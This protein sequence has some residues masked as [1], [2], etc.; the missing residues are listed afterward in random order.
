MKAHQAA[1]AC[2]VVCVALAL[3]MPWLLSP[4]SLRVMVLAVISAIAVVGLCFAFGYAGLVDLGQAAFLGI[5]AYATALLTTRAGLGFWTALPAA[6]FAG[7]V[8]AILLGAPL[9]RLR[10]HYLAL[11]TVGLNVTMEIVTKN[12][13]GL[14][15]GEDGISGIPGVALFG[16]PITTDRAYYFLALA[17]LAIAAVIGLALRASRF[18]RSMIAVRD[19][20]LAADACGVLVFRTK[21]VA[22]TLASVYGALSGVLY[23]HY[24]G[25]IAP[26]DFDSVR[27]ITLLVMLIVGGE[28]SILG[29]IG[30]AVLVSFA[31]EWLRF[32]GTAY[33]TVFGILIMLVLVLLP[34][35]AAGAVRSLLA[36]LDRRPA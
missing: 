31:P 8:L 17:F 5:G 2:I 18:G 23:A 9:L 22:F 35:G 32:L 15:G 36:R 20:E 14:T 4:Y 13:T 10:G 7:G 33:L 24:A 29:A 6:L 25:Y 28:A 1:L 34:Q 19:D 30:G 16:M 12:W 3:A 26:S 21:L 11:A 27:S